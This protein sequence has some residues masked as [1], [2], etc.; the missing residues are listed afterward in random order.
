MGSTGLHWARM[1]RCCGPQ[2]AHMLRAQ[3]SHP[4][5]WLAMGEDWTLAPQQDPCP[6]EAS[7]PAPRPSL[8]FLHGCRCSTPA[9]C[10]S[11]G[12]R[13]RHS[14]CQQCAPGGGPGR[15]NLTNTNLDCSS[16]EGSPNAGR[17]LRSLLAGR[18]SSRAT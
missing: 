9:W 13:R 4:I 6:A 15:A 2:C 14:S 1:R 10:H 18:G 8:A 12:V 7:T 11:W 17:F 3:W 5:E 16:L